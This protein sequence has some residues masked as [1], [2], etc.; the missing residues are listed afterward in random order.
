MGL[1]NLWGSWKGEEGGGDADKRRGAAHSALVSP[2]GNGELL[3]PTS[4]T[5]FV[6]SLAPPRSERMERPRQRRK[7]L[8]AAHVSEQMVGGVPAPESGWNGGKKYVTRRN[9]CR[10]TI[11]VVLCLG[12]MTS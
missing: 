7:A 11:H 2:S 4:K 5:I 3:G 9:P 10:S 6:S 8:G 12:T 1:A